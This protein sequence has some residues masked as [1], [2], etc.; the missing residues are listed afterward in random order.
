MKFK[1]VKLKKGKEIPIK[2]KHHWIFSGAVENNVNFVDGEIL[3]VCSYND[4]VL[5][6]GY[7]NKNSVIIGRMLNFEDKNPYDSIKENILSAI[8]LRLKLFDLNKTNC[9]RLINGEGDRLPGLVVDFYNFNLV[10]QISTIGIE[11]LKDFIFNSIIQIFQNKYSFKINSIYEKS[12]MS[13]RKKDGL[14]EFEGTVYGNYQKNLIVKENE[15][16]FKIDLKKSQKTGL[17]LDQ[18]E[19][20]ELIGSMSFDRSILNCFCY[21]GGFS[22]YSAKNNAKNITSID[23]SHE[24]IQNSKENFL[25]NN[26]NINDKNKYEFLSIDVFKF[27]RD[28]K[29]LNY[30]IVVLDPPAF[31]KSKKD[32]QKA[33]KAYSEIN[34]LAM[35]KMPKESFLL[36]CSCSYH[37]SFDTFQNIVINSA[38]NANKNIKII[39]KHRL[40]KDHPINGFHKE[41]DYLK[42]LLVY[43]E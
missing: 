14:Q 42:S 10:V 34:R 38:K 37:I 41:I 29:N 24:A 26:F 21:T 33:A 22:L 6:Y 23:I 28:K 16:L 15:I 3:K 32:I 11:N 17:F 31:A 9:F 7:F 35:S 40:A 25:L 1:T 30:D 4:E 5:G 2:L 12:L 36:T 20:R 13:A 27:L 39:Q 8:N 19:M 43:L 18:R